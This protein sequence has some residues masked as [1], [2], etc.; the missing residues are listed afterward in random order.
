MK[1]F[2]RLQEAFAAA[3]AV[4]EPERVQDMKDTASADVM[5]AAHRAV[6]ASVRQRVREILKELREAI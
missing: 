6:E 2:R 3:A 5:V 4:A 1:D